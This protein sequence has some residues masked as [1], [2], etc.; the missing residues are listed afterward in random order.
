MKLANLTKKESIAN[1]L[2]N[3]S[4]EMGS[5]YEQNS[6]NSVN[7]FLSYI[8]SY[9]QVT[10]LGAGDGAA[11]RQFMELDWEVTAVDINE[12]KLRSMPDAIT[13]VK[14]DFVT[15]LKKCDDDSIPNIFCHHALEHY[16][17]P[18]A[19]LKEIG[20]VLRPGG[21][22]FIAVPAGGELESVHHV[23]F[24]SADEIVPPGLEVVLRK[25]DPPLR[26]VLGEFVVIAR[27]P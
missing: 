19:V 8:P 10:D 20:R 9:N 5:Q 27:K 2:A 23:V 21:L 15:Y 1:N 25:S 7:L 17:D 13:T 11:S 22:C 24:E 3:F 16:V 4:F 12:E 18:E 6:I 26:N 14:E